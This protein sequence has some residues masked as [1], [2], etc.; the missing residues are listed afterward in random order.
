MLKK[1]TIERYAGPPD[2]ILRIGQI[3]VSLLLFY[4]VTEP[5]TERFGQ[6]EAEE[7]RN[8]NKNTTTV[9]LFISRCA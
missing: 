3:L 5:T 4:S 8:H 1:I 9:T 6:W 2:A 7:F